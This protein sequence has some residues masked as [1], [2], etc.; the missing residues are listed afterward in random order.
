[1]KLFLKLLII[2]SMT[3]TMYAA[4]KESSYITPFA[5]LARGAKNASDRFKKELKDHELVVVK[6]SMVGCPPC[7][8]V[9]PKFL[10]IAKKYHGKA[11]FLSLDVTQYGDA[12][13][14]YK[15][16]G[17]PT[18]LVFFRG[19]LSQLFTG[20]PKVKKIAPLLDQLIQKQTEQEASTETKSDL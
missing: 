8:A 13:R 20:A 5:E 19:N 17:V 12:V 7:R 3:I 4:D 1:M 18:F 6:C 15:F 14:A 16:R 2:S 11:R 9:A 10:E